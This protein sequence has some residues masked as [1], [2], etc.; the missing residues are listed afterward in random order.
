[1]DKQSHAPACPRRHSSEYLWSNE[2]KGVFHSSAL[3]F[4]GGVA[5]AVTLGQPL[6]PWYYTRRNC[7]VL[8]RLGLLGDHGNIAGDVLWFWA[9]IMWVYGDFSHI[10]YIH[11]WLT[12]CSHSHKIR[13]APGLPDR[14]VDVRQGVSVINLPKNNGL[15]YLSKLSNQRNGSV[16]EY[17]IG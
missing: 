15:R 10:V 16:A 9:R 8:V 3:L 7:P 13:F 5:R 6:F 12:T 2:A 1:M 14:N 11:M 17:E 4:V